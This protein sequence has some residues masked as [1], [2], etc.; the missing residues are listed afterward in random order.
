MKCPYSTFRLSLFLSL[1]MLLQQTPFA[2]ESFWQKV[3]RITGIS[4]I[5]SRMK[6]PGNLPADGQIWI[7]HLPA[8]RPVK[9][10]ITDE[11]GFRSPVFTPDG[12]YLLAMRSNQIWRISPENGSGSIAHTVPN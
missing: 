6:G 7:A 2:S 1:G 5:P 9:L 11:G 12:F 3:L 10:E 8:G 4:V